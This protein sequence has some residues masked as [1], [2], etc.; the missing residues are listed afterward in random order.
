MRHTFVCG[1]RTLLVRGASSCP[2]S[3]HR[4]HG[5]LSRLGAAR[6]LLSVSRGERPLTTLNTAGPAFG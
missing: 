6:P 5:T 1:R 2:G 4:K 3:F